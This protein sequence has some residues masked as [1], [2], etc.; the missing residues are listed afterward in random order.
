MLIQTGTFT[1][2]GNRRVISLDFEPIAFFIKGNHAVQ[3]AMHM[4][5]QWCGRSVG[6]ANQDSF[7]NG[8]RF[9]GS[10]VYL[11]TDT[12]VSATGV[13]F[14]WC[15]IGKDT[16]TDVE[17]VSWMG[18]GANGN[19]ITLQSGLSAIAALIKRDST[20]SGLIRATAL[21]S[22]LLDATTKPTDPVT[23][24]GV[25][26]ITLSSQTYANQYDSANGLGE[27]T[28][29]LFFLTGGAN[30]SNVSWTGN[31]S[32]GRTIAVTDAKFAIIY[33]S[34]ATNGNQAR[35]CTLDAT[36]PVGATAAVAGDPVL[37]SSA[38]TLGTAFGN[39]NTITYRALVFSG[40]G[41]APYAAPAIITS[42]KKAIYLPGR[43]V[44]SV[45]DCGTSDAT[46]NISGA[47]T[48]EWFG[49]PYYAATPSDTPYMQLI[50]R[51]AG[52]AATNN[53]YSW[54]TLLKQEDDFTLRWPGPQYF[55]LPL[56]RIDADPPLATCAWRTGVL[57][58]Y[59]KAQHVMSTF[60]GTSIWRLFVNGRLVKQ[61]N[62]AIS[63]VSQ[64]GHRTGIGAWRNAGA[65]ANPGRMA[66]ISARVY[67]SALSI[68]DCQTR[69]A[70][71]ALGSGASD[72]TANLAE[73]WD[74]STASGSNLPGQVNSANN[75]TISN[76]TIVTL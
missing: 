73:L 12:K 23:T 24:L 30:V 4:E 57:G 38:I 63:M 17:A 2:D 52:P 60:D 39:L 10:D 59:G 3:S 26:S 46:L 56:P 61:R 28:D 34:D 37:S 1:A 54:G 65:W 66:F 58:K 72:I 62:L 36:Y 8:I 29:G 75:G 67:S 45:I 6:I 47:M 76:G 7:N 21:D 19:V 5:G 42:A 33:R 70:I 68:A 48:V 14:I 49:I 35:I 31:G 20:L 50:G 22:V 43:D 53:A 71:A 16:S 18:N 32:G 44:A 9:H 69:F 27:G 25:G 40:S 41:G 74:A 13:A 15:A 55:V 51:G 64:S 11:G